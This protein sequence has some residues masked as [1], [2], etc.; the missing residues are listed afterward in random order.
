MS[1]ILSHVARM[2][3]EDG[4]IVSRIFRAENGFKV[5]AEGYGF[6]AWVD[7]DTLEK[8]E[9][10]AGEFCGLAHDV[11]EP[12]PEPKPAK[13][14]KEAKAEAGGGLGDVAEKTEQDDASNS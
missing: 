4:R 3:S 14:A 6:E 12:A 8:A 5:S 10:A 11:S 7:A 13:K 9:Q 2:T 1:A